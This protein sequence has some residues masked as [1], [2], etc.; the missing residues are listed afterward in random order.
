MGMSVTG[1]VNK[2]G[3]CRMPDTYI[4]ISNSLN[5]NEAKTKL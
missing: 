4:Y 2:A 1:G 5:Y 3:A